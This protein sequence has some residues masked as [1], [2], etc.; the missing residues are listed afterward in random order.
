MNK[1]F[2][3]VEKLLIN[4]EHAVLPGLGGFVVQ[5]QPAELRKDCLV[6][7]HAAIS[8]NPLMKHNDGM[9]IIELS[10][11]EGIS[12]K[13]ASKR[14]DK[15]IADFHRLLKKNQHLEFG[16]IREFHLNKER[17]LEFTPTLVAEFLPANFGLYTLQ[18][19]IP[20]KENK[21]LQ[22]SISARK[23]MRYAAVFV[24]LIA[25]FFSADLNKSTY[26][27]QADLSNLL[28]FNL[29]EIIVNADTNQ[30][31]E[32][33]GKANRT[34]PQNG[35]FAYKLVVATF[36]TTEKAKSFSSQL[37]SEQYPQA[38]II[39]STTN[40]KV[41]IQSFTSIVAA[42]NYLEQ[43]KHTDPRFTDAWVMKVDGSSN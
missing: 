12:Y 22:F 11:I 41:C 39:V 43:I 33:E 30:Q 9:F 18:L 29:P 7:A 25:L 4:N 26:T 21:E 13:E 15:Y 17:Q 40:T 6:P 2:D 35:R 10:R 24:T 23:M 8:F 19:P 31:Q 36:Q 34:K 42:V 28:Q 16:R 14:T 32:Y 37:K 5:Q 38:E 1:L 3:I 20:K 27:T